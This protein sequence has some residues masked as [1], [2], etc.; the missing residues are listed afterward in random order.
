MRALRLTISMSEAYYWPQCCSVSALSSALSGNSCSAWWI[1]LFIPDA[2]ETVAGR[3]LQARGS[4]TEHVRWGCSGAAQARSQAGV[5]GGGQTWD[6]STL[7]SVSKVRTLILRESNEDRHTRLL[8]DL[9]H[10]NSTHLTAHVS[11]NCFRISFHSACF[12]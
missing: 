12:F 3:G 11:Q 8:E 6:S 10:F 1:R 9:T 5:K 2:M 7:L 4:E